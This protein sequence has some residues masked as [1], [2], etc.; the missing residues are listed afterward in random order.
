MF[1]TDRGTHRVCS[2]LY[3][4]PREA[5]LRKESKGLPEAG[6]RMINQQGQSYGRCKEQVLVIHGKAVDYG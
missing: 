5:G 6:V 1:Q 2:L 3:V 4:E